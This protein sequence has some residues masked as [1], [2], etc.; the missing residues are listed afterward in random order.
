MGGTSNRISKFC[1]SSLVSGPRITRQKCWQIYSTMKFV[2]QTFQFPILSCTR[3]TLRAQIFE[4]QYAV[5][6]LVRFV[7]R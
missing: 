4:T 7:L 3:G 2:E 6:F 1:E 5:S